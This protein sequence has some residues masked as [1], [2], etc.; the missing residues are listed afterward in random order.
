M[1]FVSGSN[2][3]YIN[4]LHYKNVTFYF[5]RKKLYLFYSRLKENI[6][7]EKQNAK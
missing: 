4:I 5:K 2:S 6:K 7:E 3:V 1:S